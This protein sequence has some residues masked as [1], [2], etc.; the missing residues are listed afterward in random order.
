VIYKFDFLSGGQRL[1]ARFTE[2]GQFID[3]EVK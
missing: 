2:A 3:E 1:R